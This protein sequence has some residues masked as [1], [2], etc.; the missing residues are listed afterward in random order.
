MLEKTQKKKLQRKAGWK[1]QKIKLKIKKKKDRKQV[2][3]AQKTQV[4]KG[5]EG[6][7]ENLYKTEKGSCVCTPP[8]LNASRGKTNKQERARE[9]LGD[10]GGHVTSSA[11][12]E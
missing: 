3:K 2:R 5:V 8:P 1:I 6:G 4:Y 7:R 11:A 12:W 9:R 10:T